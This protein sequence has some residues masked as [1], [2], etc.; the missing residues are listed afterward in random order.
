MNDICFDAHNAGVQ[1]QD[2][3]GPFHLTKH[4]RNFEK[5]PNYILVLITLVYK[6]SMG[7]GGGRRFLFNQ[8]F[9]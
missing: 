7:K 2:G 1:A 3:G 5:G 8:T 6:H 4:S 9:P